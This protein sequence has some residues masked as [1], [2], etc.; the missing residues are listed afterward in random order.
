MPFQLFSVRESFRVAVKDSLG[1]W[2]SE[3]MSGVVTKSDELLED[4]DEW[5]DHADVRALPYQEVMDK[6]TACGTAMQNFLK[7]ID[8]WK[9]PLNIIEQ[10][11]TFRQ[12]HSSLGQALGDLAEYAS[13][14]E[15]LVASQSEGNKAH[16]RRQRGARDNLMAALVREL[17]PRIIARASIVSS[18]HRLCRRPLDCLQDAASTASAADPSPPLPPTASTAS[19]A[20]TASAADPIYHLERPCRRPHLPPLPPTPLPPTPFN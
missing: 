3:T 11:S 18:I 7:A 5:K 4:L 12:L 14:L 1:R 10:R 8:S 2:Q 15:H 17:C 19:N 20:S 9:L 16:K 6:A 13:A